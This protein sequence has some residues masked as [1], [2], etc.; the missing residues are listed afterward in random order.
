MVKDERS[1]RN[2]TG[3]CELADFSWNKFEF[4]ADLSY[5]L[6]HDK[7]T[8]EEDDAKKVNTTDGGGRANDYIAIESLMCRQ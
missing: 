7:G 1:P 2:L 3:I 6:L 8:G 4:A 5:L